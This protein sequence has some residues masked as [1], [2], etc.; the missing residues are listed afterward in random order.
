[1]D[2]DL[3]LSL[4]MS[5]IALRWFKNLDEDKLFVYG[6]VRLRSDGFKNTF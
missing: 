2:K 3:T 6:L 5:A 4:Q 1:L